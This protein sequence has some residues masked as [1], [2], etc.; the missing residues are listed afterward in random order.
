[1][2]LNT[3]SSQST[4]PVRT[5]RKKYGRRGAQD[6]EDDAEDASA[7]TQTVGEDDD[8]DQTKG[9]NNEVGSTTSLLPSS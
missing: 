9:V 1:M 4:Q 7:N 6:S 3:R 8:L 5:Q 2:P